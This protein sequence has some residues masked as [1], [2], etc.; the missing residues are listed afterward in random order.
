MKVSIIGVGR[1]GGATAFAILLK[2][3]AHELV[4]VGRDRSK[5]EGDAADLM[6]AAAFVRPMK[7]RAGDIS[8]TAG[9]D[10]VIV[11]AGVSGGGPRLDYARKNYELYRDLIPRLARHA[12]GAIVIVITNPV[13]VMTYA[14]LQFGGYA[15]GKV[16]GTGTLIDTGR[17]RA[18]LSERWRIHAYD[19][20]AYILGE[21]GDSQFPALSVA[22][23]GGVKFDEHD[24]FVQQAADEA[25]RGGYEVFRLKGH[26]NY[27]IAQ[28]TALIV[29]AIA[30]D[31]HSVIPLS[32]L[33]QGWHGVQNVCLSVPCVVGSEGIVQT[34]P[35]DLN[36]A[37]IE[38][39]QA[40]AKVMREVIDAMEK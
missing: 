33:I 30:D 20:R 2:G 18:I 4:L 9:S 31:S 16:F 19:V 13:D 32:T 7:I 25:K 6:H 34:L 37:E 17:F 36:Q 39:F 27:A 12:P 1:V 5:I 8:D 23:A 35:I 11:T 28:S 14:A 15:P 26:T 38:R 21:H 10:I 3:L 40:S 24:A 29:E 22:S